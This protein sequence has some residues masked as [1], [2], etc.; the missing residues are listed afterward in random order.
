MQEESLA[1]RLGRTKDE[2]SEL[3]KVYMERYPAVQAFFKEAVEEAMNHG[4][5]WTVLGRRRFLEGIVSSNRQVQ[6]EAAR[7]ATNTPIQGCLPASTKILTKEGYIPIG[8]APLAGVAWTGTSWE[9]YTKL[10]RGQCE[11]AELTLSNGQTLTCDTRHSVLVLEHGAY[12]FKKWEDL[13]VGDYVCM[14]LAQPIDTQTNPDLDASDCYWMGFALGNGCTTHGAGHPNALSVTFGN[15]KERY[16]K[17]QKSEEFSK[18]ILHRYGVSTQVPRVYD[19]K[20]TIVAENSLIASIWKSWGYPWGD[21]SKFK[22]VPK[23]IWTSSL[24]QRNAFLL[25]LLDSDG[26]VG[27]RTK[28][29]P[30][31]HLGQRALLED[32]QILFR[33]SGV[34]STLRDLHDG[35][36]RLDVNGAQAAEHLNYGHPRNSS[37]K[38]A[39]MNVSKEVIDRVLQTTSQS[40]THA[41]LKL[42]TARTNQISPYTAKDMLRK[43]KPTVELYAVR[44]L[45][46][47]RAL[48]RVET[49]YTLSVDS[50]LH[51]YDSEGVISKNS[52]ADVVKMAMVRLHF[53]GKLKQRFGCNMQMQVHDELIFEC[54]EETVN[55]CKPVIKEF[56]EHSFPQDLAVPLTISMG[57]G[58]NW[59]ETH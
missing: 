42:R 35:S 24:Q 33:I 37:P 38:I 17:E 55:D 47:K 52:A 51:R 7:Q 49:T 56:M 22:R 57:V 12:A 34:E 23:Y 11:L 50:S 6:A 54:P 39:G 4:Y 40:E 8:D 14:T 36:F 19:G 1:R 28:N 16:T 41:T 13:T 59:S 15:R 32:V 20:I 18:Y 43:E 27:E 9:A 21:T 2:A 25:G 5:A 3:M 48:G 53:D 26:S 46:G 10:D 29:G 45:I 30:N 31:I 58:N 44:Q